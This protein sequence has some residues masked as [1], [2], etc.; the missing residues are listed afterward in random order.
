MVIEFERGLIAQLYALQLFHKLDESFR[1]LLQAPDQFRIFDVTAAIEDV[2]HHRQ[3]D[4]L[5]KAHP[6]Q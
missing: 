3:K 1:L 5:G 2:V 4:A 6:L